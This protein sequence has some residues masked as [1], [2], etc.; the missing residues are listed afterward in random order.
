MMAFCEF[1]ASSKQN[2]SKY[3]GAKKYPLLGF[4]C[5]GDSH[6]GNPKALAFE[7]PS[8]NKCDAISFSTTPP[9]RVKLFNEVL[10][11]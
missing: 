1:L 5:S 10:T 11:E 2:N 4:V 6:D 8:I 9:D 7:S 3:H